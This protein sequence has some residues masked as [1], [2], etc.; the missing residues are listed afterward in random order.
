MSVR[1]AEQAP[2]LP[3]D[4]AAT[5][6]PAP[7]PAGL[8]S[9]VALLL[10]VALAALSVVALPL[11]PQLRNETT[12]RWPAPGQPVESTML[13]LAPYRPLELHATVPCSPAAPPQAGVLL[14][15]FPVV[16]P[17]AGRGLRVALDDGEVTVA[18][19][20][21]PVWTGPV[22]ARGCVLRID[23]VGDVTTVRV[24]DRVVARD[25]VDPPRT[26]ALATGLPKGTPGLSAV[27]LTD[28]RFETS[29]TLLKKAVALLA[30]LAG[31]AC[32]VL[33]AALDPRRQRHARRRRR[34]P[35]AQDGV[36]LAV[37]TAWAMV[38]P[39]LAD[40]GFNVAVADG[41][42]D[43][44]TV[45]NRY[46]WYNA[47]ETPF[48]LVQQ[49]LVPLVE[50]GRSP[51][52]L[53]LPA[54]LAAVATW[55]L[56]SRWLLPRLAGDHSLRTVQWLGL[57]AFLAWWMPYDLGVRPEPFV[58][59]AATA[60]LV[61]VLHAVDTGRLLPLA[62][63]GVVAALAFATAPSG[64]IAATPYVVLARRVLPLLRQRVAPALL[65]AA[66]VVTPGVVTL[67]VAVFLDTGLA[68]LV[69]STRVHSVIGPTFAWWE[70]AERYGLLFSETDMGVFARR[71]PVLLAAGCL[72]L[73]AATR[74]RSADRDL[75][76]IAGA[77]M[78]LAF[79]ALVLTPSKWTHHFGGMAGLGAVLLAGAALQARARLRD[80]GSPA[81]TVAAV[82][83]AATLAAAGFAGP[84]LWVTYSTFGIDP[85]LPAPLRS[86]VLWLVVAGVVAAVV[87]ARAR[88]GEVARAV[89]GTVVALALVT[90]V[91]TLLAT[92]AHSTAR[93]DGGW[94]MARENLDHLTGVSCG[95]ADHVEVL[96]PSALAPALGLGA[97][98]Q[99]PE[100]S[101]RRGGGFL[102]APKNL[103]PSAARWGTYGATAGPGLAPEA[104]TGRLVSTWYE[105]P[106]LPRGA[107]LGIAVS[108]STR[109]ANSVV[110]QYASR[111][112]PRR[113]LLSQP[114]VDAPLPN[115]RTVSGAPREP[116]RQAPG[117]ADWRYVT[118]GA[119]GPGPDADLV[120]VVVTDASSG[121]DGWVASTQPLL[122]TPRLLRDVLVP[123]TTS[124]DFSVALAFPCTDQVE[125]AHGIAGL[126]TY[127]ITSKPD[128]NA[129]RSG[130]L[131]HEESQG[132]TLAMA[133]QTAVVTVL[134]TRMRGALPEDV[135]LDRGWG[136]LARYDFPYPSGRYEVTVR[137]ELHSSLDWGYRYPVPLEPDP[138]EPFDP[139]DPLSEVDKG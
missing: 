136:T 59:L 75:L 73:L 135:L 63:G 53:R 5:P 129:V 104:G 98:R 122:M 46:R 36:L 120:R 105:V 31:L 101:F 138:L 12:V 79:A 65:V 61:L 34:W 113:T 114:V 37:L 110:V 27:L 48:A 70:E 108:G 130:T 49:A 45:G 52:L 119:G 55:V 95:M 4:D 22:P 24:G 28:S 106:D 56:L 86:P 10:A 92:F 134:P 85:R 107:E 128:R 66:A 123:G 16:G 1:S 125:L 38:G 62:V 90:S 88:A 30:T 133:R 50:I 3:P 121:R 54:V 57:A 42:T 6:A 93:L 124:V 8:L 64:L 39:M 127:G 94:S 14:S 7:R 17:G 21:T 15:T 77:C 2:A 60:V 82:L 126:P 87:H 9:P 71:L 118:F 23:A 26:A 117:A 78:A 74:R 89:P 132:G 115:A 72:V 69:E 19:D 47:P 103:P 32:L 51:W 111:E 68:A 137:Q 97:E 20:G 43:T 58:A 44:G 18:T 109:G 112:Q 99:V 41:F 83:G 100:G 116:R 84:N 91:V 35:W 80:A 67:G 139:F 11:L 102:P 96:Q 131:Q 81:W 33:L 25:V 76:P 40:D 13:T 29:P